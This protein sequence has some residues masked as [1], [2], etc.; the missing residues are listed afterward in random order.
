M[1]IVASSYPVYL[2]IRVQPFILK[3]LFIGEVEQKGKRFN[4][5]CLKSFSTFSKFILSVQ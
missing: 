4:Q 3:G 2:Q 5:I 1:S